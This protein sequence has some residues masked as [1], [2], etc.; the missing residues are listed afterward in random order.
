MQSP[1]TEVNGFGVFSHN[2]FGAKESGVELEVTPLEGRKESSVRVLSFDLD[3][4]EEVADFATLDGAI[5]RTVLR[6]LGRIQDSVFFEV[7]KC[8][9][10]AVSNS[11]TN[12]FSASDSETWIIVGL[13]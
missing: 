12:L 7:I 2:P 10:N 13:A 8:R 5:I 1:L 9:Q 6:T 11:A 4:F 3:F